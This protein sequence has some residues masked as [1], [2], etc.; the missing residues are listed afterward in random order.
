MTK[1]NMKQDISD[2]PHMMHAH[3]IVQLL[4]EIRQKALQS[5]PLLGQLPSIET[6]KLLL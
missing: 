4:E 5:L 3:D 1:P 2:L 6:A